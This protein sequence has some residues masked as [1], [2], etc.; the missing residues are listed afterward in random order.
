MNDKL[1]SDLMEA[2]SSFGE[3]QKRIC[4]HSDKNDLDSFAYGYLIGLDEEMFALSMVR[5]NGIFAGARF[6]SIRVPA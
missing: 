6:F 2:L 5:P 3:F 1:T 4:I